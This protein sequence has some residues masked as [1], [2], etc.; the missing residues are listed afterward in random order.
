MDITLITETQPRTLVIRTRCP[1]HSTLCRHG[2]HA[3]TSQ[4]E[5][6]AS[7][8]NAYNRTVT[9]GGAQTRAVRLSRSPHSSADRCTDMLKLQSPGY[10]L[11][12]TAVPSFPS[13]TS[14]RP[15]NQRYLRASQNAY[16]TGRDAEASSGV[17]TGRCVRACYYTCDPAYRTTSR[18]RCKVTCA[19]RTTCGSARAKPSRKA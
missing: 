11:P 8:R 10:V 12:H 15:E 16:L 4:A 7:S 5:K 9:S 2:T 18:A 17:Q 14:H 3:L 6:P 13:K 1:P 19:V